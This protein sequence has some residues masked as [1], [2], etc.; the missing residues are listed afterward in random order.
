MACKLC[1]TRGKNWGGSDPVCSFKARI[2]N[3]EGWNCAT[4]NVLREIAEEH[5]TCYVGDQRYAVIPLEDGVLLMSW[6]KGR[7][8][9]DSALFVNLDGN[10]SPLLTAH[11]ERLVKQY[12]KTRNKRTINNG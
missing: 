4:M 9:T 8:R 1:Q 6:Y 2:F 3:K 7:G 10:S 12:I 11:A 5:I